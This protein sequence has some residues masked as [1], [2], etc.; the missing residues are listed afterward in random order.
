MKSGRRRSG[1]FGEH[2]IG[3]YETRRRLNITTTAAAAAS[4]A[5]P[6]NLAGIITPGP[7]L[8]ALQLSTPDPKL[9]P[10]LADAHRWLDDLTTG[11]VGSIRE[12][13]RRYGRDKGE[14]SRI[15]PLAFLAPY[16]IAAILH[17]RQPVFR[18]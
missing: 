13:A 3:R 4:G 1:N 17:G 7:R 2:R 10:L 8:P 5:D 14:V 18:P 9:M 16:I 11:R 12:L 6:P 15:L